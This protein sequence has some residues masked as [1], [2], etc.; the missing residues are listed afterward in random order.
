MNKNETINGNFLPS[1]TESRRIQVHVSAE[2]DAIAAG[3]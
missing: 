2:S 3:E 1:A